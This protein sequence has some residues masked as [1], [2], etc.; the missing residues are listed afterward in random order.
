M[1]ESGKSST[2]HYGKE[3]TVSRSHRPRSFLTIGI[4]S[5]FAGLAL[6]GCALAGAAPQR[7]ATDVGAPHSAKASP[8]DSRTIRV[9]AQLL[10]GEELDLGAPGRSVGDQFIFSGNLLST[11]KSADRVA[12]R[13]GGFCVVTDLERNAGQCSTTAVLPEGQ[14]AVQG[15]QEGIPAFPSPVTNAITGGTGE[16]RKAQGQMT[17]RVLTPATWELT[18][19][20]TGVRSQPSGD[21][22]SPS[23]RAEESMPTSPTFPGK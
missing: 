15:E 23:E 8:K 17:R 2:L 4:L 3:A 6:A 12:G 22:T 5:S 9:E 19:Q 20:V 7:A 14:I 11:G 21:S 1:H 13:L 18:F 16:F 10:V